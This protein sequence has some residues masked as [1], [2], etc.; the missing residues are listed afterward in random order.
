MEEGVKIV[1]LKP[2]EWARYKALRLE[3]LQDTPSAFG[4]AYRE[5]AA[6]PDSSWIERLQKSEKRDKS[7]LLFAEA[8][9]QLVGMV[10]A[11]VDK[12]ENT[13]HRAHII[14]VY[15]TPRMREKGIARAL[16]EA[17]MREIAKDPQIIALDLDVT[18]GNTAAEELYKK[19]GFKEV[20]Y[21]EKEMCIDGTYVDTRIMT[22]FIR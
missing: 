10:G 22:K 12:L 18:A 20:G 11:Y 16:G 21:K 15:V 1:E 5:A 13:R 8:E 3:A 4:T 9:G 14:A 6:D 19:L 2:D 17:L 7:W